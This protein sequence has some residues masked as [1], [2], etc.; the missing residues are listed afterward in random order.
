MSRLDLFS[1]I[2]ASLHCHQESTTTMNCPSIPFSQAAIGGLPFG[3]TF[4]LAWIRAAS[5]LH[6]QVKKT[7]LASTRKK[8]VLP[9]NGAFPITAT[10]FSVWLSGIAAPL[11]R[12][13]K[14][15][16]PGS[17]LKAARNSFKG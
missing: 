1:V 4:Q 17:A 7:P 14:R 6:Y 8:H 5:L 11:V 9:P 16:L 12:A 13:T 3:S 10:C 15:P 2:G